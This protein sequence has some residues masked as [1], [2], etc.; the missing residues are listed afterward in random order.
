MVHL[1]TYRIISG[2]CK[3]IFEMYTLLSRTYAAFYI[4]EATFCNLFHRML[5]DIF[6]KFSWNFLELIYATSW[7]LPFGTYRLLSGTFTEITDYFEPKCYFLEVKES[8]LWVLAECKF[9]ES[10]DW[11]MYEY[12]FFL[13]K[14]NID[15]NPLIIKSDG[16]YYYPVSIYIILLHRRAVW[17]T[18]C[19]SPTWRF[20]TRW[21]MTF[22]IPDV[23]RRD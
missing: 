10:I 19:T 6:L 20:T 12:F 14:C 2:S 21:D 7:N 3:L 11:C 5:Y 23:R 4:L 1:G 17:C 8:T 15:Y 13:A 9:D 22:W 16:L 18:P